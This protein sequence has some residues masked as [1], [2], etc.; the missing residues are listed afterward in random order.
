M[1][2]TGC[3]KESGQE[4]EEQ[5]SI[6][7]KTAAVEKGMLGDTTV[8]TGK[9][10]ALAS[11]DVVPGGQGGKVDAVSVEV[12]HRVSK[13]QTLISLE[14]VSQQAA[15]QQA[16]QAVLQAES[17]LELAGITYEQAK[18]NYERGK[19]LYQA[20]SISLGGTTGFETAF[21]IPYKK[22]KIDY[23]QVKPATLENAKAALA[24]A[25]DAYNNTFIKSPVNGVVTAINVDPGELASPASPVPAV[26]V[27]NL[28]KTIVKATVTEDQINKIAQGQEVPVLVSAVSDKPFTGVITNIA[29][30]ADQVSKAYPIKVQINNPE[31]KLKPGM[32]AEVQLKNEQQEML[33]V[34]RQAVIKMGGR[35][36]VWVVNDNRVTSCLVTVGVSDGE[37]IG[38]KEGIEEGQQIVISGQDS[39]KENAQVE[40]NN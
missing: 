18:A 21:E 31:H 5:S 36:T 10:E 8:V 39:L 34:P 29:L 33:L 37:V 2:L 40:I 19:E 38:I 9:L 24:K 30:A 12:G 28:D 22:A 11:S 3:G 7:V 26:S 16:E 13:G 4:G 17:A 25:Q 6:P 20:G 32:F 1:T 27:V 35:D 23:E 15:V 14:N